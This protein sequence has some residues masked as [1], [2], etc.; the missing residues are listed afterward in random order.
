MSG[1]TAGSHPNEA[2]ELDM[3]HRQECGGKKRT[4]FLISDNPF[5]GTFTG[6]GSAVSF[7]QQICNISTEKSAPTGADLCA[8]FTL[9]TCCGKPAVDPTPVNIP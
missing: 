5:Q 7:P 3:A 6:V 4:V 8:N 2:A 1:I 9:R